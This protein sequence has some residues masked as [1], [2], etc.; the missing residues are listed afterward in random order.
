VR[1]W[2]GGVSQGA[3]ECA[4]FCSL[5]L[6]PISPSLPSGRS[7]SVA[8]YGLYFTVGGELEPF[9]GPPS[10]ISMCPLHP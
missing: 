5:T 9:G 8:L 3:R 1:A 6:P 4:G 7:E 10:E 2:M